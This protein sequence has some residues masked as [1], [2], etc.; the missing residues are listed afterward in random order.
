MYKPNLD[1]F[2]RYDLKKKENSMSFIPKYLKKTEAEEKLNDKR[3]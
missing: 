1:R 2:Y 3:D